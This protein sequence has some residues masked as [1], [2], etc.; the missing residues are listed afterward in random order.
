MPR[1]RKTPEEL[2]AAAAARK[3]KQRERAAQQAQAAA[4]T[5]AIVGLGEPGQPAPPPPADVTDKDL[6]KMVRERLVSLFE[7]MTDED[8]LDKD[9]KHIID[10][11]LKTA[12]VFDRRAAKQDGSALLEQGKLLLMLV[13]GEAPMEALPDPTVVEGTA[14]EVD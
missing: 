8:L 2:R 11:M 7:N 1:P 14:R 5:D 6:A 10:Q 3:R 12:S 4:Y 9:H 13:R